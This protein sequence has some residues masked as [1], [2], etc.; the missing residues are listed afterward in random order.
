MANYYEYGNAVTIYGNYDDV[1]D[2]PY[3]PT[4]VKVVVTSPAQV[5]TTYVYTVDPEVVKLSVGRYSMDI[6]LPAVGAWYYRW[7]TDDTEYASDQAWF[8]VLK[9]KN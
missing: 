1:D 8:E 5:A 2:N 7:Y 3:D 4:V 9:I 6:I